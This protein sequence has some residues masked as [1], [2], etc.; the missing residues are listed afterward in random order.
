MENFEIAEMNYLGPTHISVLSEAM[1][2]AFADRAKFM[3]DPIFAP[4]IPLKGLTSKEYA[5]SLAVQI[6]I[7]IQN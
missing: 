2:M 4:E 3:A 7:K 6:D 5:K 1:K